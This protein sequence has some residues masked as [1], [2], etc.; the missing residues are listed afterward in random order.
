MLALAGISGACTIPEPPGQAST[1]WA[2]IGPGGGGSTFLPT[3]S[4]HDPNLMLLRCDMSGAYLTRD[5]GQSWRMLNF[6]GGA[7]AFA[8]HPEDPARMYVGATGLHTSE[9]GGETWRLV[10]PDPGQVRGMRHLGDHASVSY[11]TDDNFPSES[12]T[13]RSILVTPARASAP[14]PVMAALG[15]RVFASLDDG[16]TW[17][18]AAEL[19][20]QVLRLLPE[21]PDSRRVLVVTRETVLTLDAATLEVVHHEAGLPEQLAPLAWI[22]G[23]APMD[24]GGLEFWALREGR[25]GM[26][27]ALYRST[28]GWSSWQEVT[29]APSAGSPRPS[30]F[31]HLAAAP[32][33]P[34]VAYVV[35]SAE[36]VARASGEPGLWYGILR[37]DDGGNSWR[38][39]YRAGGG[40]SDYTIRDGQEA[41][42]L[43]DSWVKEAFSG[44]FISAIHVG[45]NPRD[46]EHAVFTDWYRTMQTRDG[47]GIWDAL[48]SENLPDGTV[49]SRGLDVT[50]TYGVHF[51]PFDPAHI[52]ISYTDIGYF[53]SR[54]GGK[55]WRRSVEGVPPAWDNTVYWMQFDPDRPGRIWSGWSSRHDLPKLKMIRDPDWLERTEGGVCRSDDGGKTWGVTSEGLPS[56]SSVTSLLLDPASPPDRRRLWATSFGNGVYR[57]ED[58]G[59]TWQDVSKGLGTNRNAWELTMGAD[60]AVYLVVTHGTRFEGGQALPDLLNGEVYRFEPQEEAWVR[61]TL[62]AGLRFPNSLA[63]DPGRPDRLWIAAWG[64]M[65]KGEFGSFPDPRT[66]LESA[67]GVWISEDGG[68]SWRQQLSDDAYVYAVTVDSRHP[69]RVYCNTFHREA[70]RSD[71]DGET[72]R[73]IE[74]Y[75]F[76]WG[77]RVILDPQDANGVYITTFGGSVFHGNP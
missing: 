6:P 20:G 62:P 7:Q 25:R 67:G 65:T 10:F 30:S 12:V 33:S 13:V 77:H 38:W 66:L 32:S 42:N 56:N 68:A 37:T 53:H 4:P 48:Y 23:G 26:P 59:E 17:Q 2:V 11:L 61:L 75:D 27:S 74:G 18:L 73:R 52:A 9:D 29:P 39:V 54:D 1:E 31:S 72:W 45:V 24:S 44:E 47:G 40:S 14:N 22:D 70:W 58:D 16:K 5:G 28:G 57:S 15:S 63:P 35:C 46:P 71:N 49:R 41:E 36:W 55:T 3:I 64:G 51:D 69:G 21:G 19:A 43:R 8:F 60:G 34:G 76:R 50:T